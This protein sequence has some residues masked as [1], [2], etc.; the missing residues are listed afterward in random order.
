MGENPF[1]DP[2]RFERRAPPCAIVIFGANGDLTKRKLLPAL[3]RLASDG[4]LPPAFAI[5]GNSRTPMSDDDFRQKMRE[6][7]E[8]FQEDAPFDASLWDGFAANLFYV[9]GDLKDEGMY[10][11]LGEKLTSVEQSH[12]T[13]GNVLFYLSTQPSY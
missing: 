10:K 13:A 5:I 7:V 11:L 3:Y 12:R 2:L 4:R 6:A 8:Q 9:A 1:A